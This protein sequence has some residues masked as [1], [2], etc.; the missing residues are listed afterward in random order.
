MRE[1]HA[2]HP[3]DGRKCMEQQKYY[4]HADIVT[5]EA[6]IVARILKKCEST[7][8][9][10]CSRSST[11]EEPTPCP[12]GSGALRLKQH[13]LQASIVLERSMN[14]SFS[15]CFQ[16]SAVSVMVRGHDAVGA[17][18]QRAPPEYPNGICRDVPRASRRTWR[19][20]RIVRVAAW[21]N[22]YLAIDRE[23]AGRI[24]SGPAPRSHIGNAPRTNVSTCTTKS[25]GGA[26]LGRRSRN[27]SCRCLLSPRAIL[28]SSL[29]AFI[30]CPSVAFVHQ[31]HG[32][33]RGGRRLNASAWRWPG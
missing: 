5:P 29:I 33:L 12:P 10:S 9:P 2:P 6:A 16:N 30:K 17:F 1:E 28:G 31:A 8:A 25:T 20:A 18:R 22:N 19:T 13:P 3:H 21:C 15:S 27:I 26:P 14:I 23:P 32:S 4:H 7:H 11:T 24:L